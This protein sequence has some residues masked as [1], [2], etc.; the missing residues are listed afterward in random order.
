MTS[1][2]LAQVLGGA[3][4]MRYRN[5]GHRRLIGYRVTC[6]DAQCSDCYQRAG[7]LTA[8]LSAGG[9]E[10]WREPI[11]ISSEGDP[12]DSPTH[13]RDCHALIPHQLTKAGL[14]LVAQTIRDAIA[15]PWAHSLPSVR[16][17]AAVYGELTDL[18][19]ELLAVTQSWPDQ[20]GPAT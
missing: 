20:E 2:F 3:S 7:G 9:F 15:Y 1:R 6:E 11:P 16:L 10:D 12:A 13:C 8:W 14:T 5:P 19:S 4:A 17:W 18:P